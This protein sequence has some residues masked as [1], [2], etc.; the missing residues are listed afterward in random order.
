MLGGAASP[1]PLQGQIEGQ[2]PQPTAA[3]NDPRPTVRPTRAD[4]APIVDGRLDD[5]IWQ[6]AAQITGLSQQRPLDGAPATEE[7]IIKVAYD[8]DNIYFAFDVRYSDSSVMRHSR[9]DRDRASQDDLM[10]VYFD[11]FMDGQRVYDFDLNGYNVQ[12]D[13]VLGVNSPGGGSAAIPRADRT[14]DAIWYSKTEMLA[15]GFTAEIA[16]PFK[17]MRYPARAPGEPHR[18]GFQL[19]REIKGKNNEQ[20]V[21]APMSRSEANFFVQMGFFEGMTDLGTNRNLEVMPQLTALRVGSIDPTQAEMASENSDP[22]VGLN[23]KYG[24]TSNLTADFTVHPDFSQVETDSPVIEINRRDPILFAELRPFFVEGAEIFNISGPVTFVHTRTIVDPMFGT[25][26]SGK[27]GP[28]AIGIVAANDRA[29]GKVDDP[30]DPAFD[31]SARTLIARARYDLYAQSTLGGV[32]TDREF[33]DGYS[34]LGAIDANFRLSSSVSTSFREVRSRNQDNAGNTVD[35]HMEQAR[36]GR[37]GRRVGATLDLY[38]ISPDFDTK[39]GFVSRR[40]QRVISSDLRYTFYP[41]SWILN[42]G[43]RV[44]YSSSWNFDDVH[45]DNSVSGNVA[46][47][48]SRL[49]NLSGSVTQAM[50]RYRFPKDPASSAQDFDKSTFSVNA[51]GDVGS[52]GRIRISGNFSTGDEIRRVSSPFLGE[53]HNWGLSAALK[54]IPRLAYSLGI[55]SSRFTDPRNNDAE[56]FDI[57]I[58]RGSGTLQVTDRLAVRNITEYNTSRIAGS[59]KAFVFNWLFTYRINAGTVAYAGY[60]DRYQQANLI[61]SGGHPVFNADNESRQPTNRLFFVKFQYLF[62]Y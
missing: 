61:T 21:W 5:P 20:L 46:F 47:E 3:V 1:S 23:V 43:P 29:P 41:E 4:V 37:N 26:L 39:V 62:R 18:W 25:K 33:L 48:F 54:P 32:V 2:G 38:Q 31:Q 12:G 53:Q 56:V 7:T 36:I 17:S 22:Q 34:R 52:G 57:K 14:W 13:G 42:W 9:V 45:Q 55:S 60:D 28:F 40:D 27:V 50:E 10:T 24:L 8:G 51:S 49:I 16:I 35:G 58:L 30:L 6:T 11:T 44:A 15:G 59:G 19:V